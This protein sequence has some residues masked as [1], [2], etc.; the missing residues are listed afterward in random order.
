MTGDAQRPAKRIGRP[1]KDPALGK[2]SNVM[3]RL[4]E[5]RKEMLMQA[6][7]AEG[8]SMSEEIE[9][10]LEASFE[11]TSVAVAAGEAARMAIEE[12]QDAFAVQA[13][14]ST[15]QEL[16]EDLGH[17]YALAV[18]LHMGQSFTEIAERIRAETPKE[19]WL[20]NPRRMEEAAAMM[21]SKLDTMF[22]EW[23]RVIFSANFWTLF[24]K[25]S[26]NILSKKAD[27]TYVRRAA[28]AQARREAEAAEAAGCREV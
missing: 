27:G 3:F 1:L 12:A 28:E 24:Q 9:K 4:S 17:P 19:I 11:S 25:Y 14:H 21:H 18:A 6:A 23:N 15:L 26:K 22:N 10:R 8:R 7:A 16:Q 20:D 13:I 2:R 5:A